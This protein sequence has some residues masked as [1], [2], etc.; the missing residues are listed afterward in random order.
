MKLH[1]INQSACLHAEAPQLHLS[2]VCYRLL[3]IYHTTKTVTIK[4][5]YYSAPHWHNGDVYSRVISPF[6]FLQFSLSVVGSEYVLSRPIVDLT[7][8]YILC[9][10]CLFTSRVVAQ[11]G[12]CYGN[13]DVWVAVCH[14][15][16]CVQTTKPILKLFRQSGSPII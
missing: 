11:R 5:W 8:R 15:R 7:R 2:V 9:S 1:T 10:F 14:S 4:R 16:Y 13:V 6:S 12:I 3:K